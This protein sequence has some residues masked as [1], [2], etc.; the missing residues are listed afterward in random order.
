MCPTCWALVPKPLGDLVYEAFNA[1]KRAKTHPNGAWMLAADAAIALVHLATGR[2][3]HG[4]LLPGAISYAIGMDGE[5]EA[6]AFARR[7][8]AAASG[9]VVAKLREAWGLPDPTSR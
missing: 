1:G 5:E 3:I 8:V 7:V 9:P 2:P 4:R 6:L